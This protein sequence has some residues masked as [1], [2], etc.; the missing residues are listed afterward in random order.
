MVDETERFE[1]LADETRLSIMRVLADERR[2]NWERQ[3]MGFTQLRRAVGATDGGRFNYH[4]DRLVG[5]FVEHR[6]ETYYLTDAGLEVVDAVLAGAYG[7]EGDQ[8]SET[9]AM[10][11]DCGRQLTVVH[12]EMTFRLQCPDHGVLFGTTLPAAASSDRAAETVAVVGITDMRQDMEW[13]RMGV[14]FRCW[15]T[16]VGELAATLP[17]THPA[18]GDPLPDSHETDGPVTVFG[19]DRCETVF[20]TPPSGALWGHPAV[21]AFSHDHGL[22][23]PLDVPAHETTVTSTDPFSATVTF[24]PPDDAT[25]LQV[26]LDETAS[27]VDVERSSSPPLGSE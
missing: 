11:C 13:A 7:Q 24:T 12:E 17:E 14:C 3:G 1:L 16:M 9:V 4:L 22:T 15:G 10:Q 21:T 20:W 23:D 2:V 19:C 18:T 25:T 8:T 5:T 6:D 26:Q 27:I